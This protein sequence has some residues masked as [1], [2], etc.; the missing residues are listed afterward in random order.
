MTT[1]EIWITLAKLLRSSAQQ[2]QLSLLH[3]RT[4][5]SYS[6]RTARGEESRKFTRDFRAYIQD[7]SFLSHDTYGSYLWD[8]TNFGCVCVSINSVQAK[9]LSISANSMPKLAYVLLSRVLLICASYNSFKYE[10]QSWYS[11]FSSRVVI[12]ALSISFCVTHWR[13]IL[14][15]WK[16]NELFFEAV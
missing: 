11:I 3:V 16:R 13:S 9:H 10:K 5:N 4:C 12:F 7:M 8:H 14:Y 15:F 1:G 6:S 2:K